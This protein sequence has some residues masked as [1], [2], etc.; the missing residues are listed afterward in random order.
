MAKNI[1]L[2]LLLAT[3]CTSYKRCM[4]KYGSIQADTTTVIDTVTVVKPVDSIRYVFNRDSLHYIV[5]ETERTRLVINRDTIICM[6]K[7]DTVHHYTKTI[8]VRKQPVFKPKTPWWLVPALVGFI[9]L[10]ITIFF[11]RK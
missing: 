9:L 6:A 4:E 2:L 3:S 11:T 1:V 8:E 7:S 5:R 10:L